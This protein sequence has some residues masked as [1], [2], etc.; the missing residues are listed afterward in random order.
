MDQY[1]EIFIASVSQNFRGQGLATEL[2]RRSFDIFKKNG[3]S[4]IK[5]MASSP[6]TRKL[7]ASLNFEELGC[8]KFSEAMDE[9][10]NP[11]FPNL[12]ESDDGIAVLT[13]LKL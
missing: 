5:C 9:D 8:W 6:F 11:I 10:G 2:F 4:I 7:A 3:D 1:G 13:V 12:S